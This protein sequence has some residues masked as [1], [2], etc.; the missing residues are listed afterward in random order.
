M[1][2]FSL[3]ISQKV[4]RSLAVLSGPL[5]GFIVFMLPLSLEK[6]GQASLAVLVFCACW[7]LLGAV[8]L[9]V[10]SLVGLGL[11]PVLG[12]LPIPEALS[13]FGNQAVFFV[14]GLH[15]FLRSS[16]N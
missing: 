3:G 12:A 7:W 13:L 16:T 1:S 15:Y 6:D 11:S 9:P 10:T 5:L 8:P 2:F 4:R 14:V